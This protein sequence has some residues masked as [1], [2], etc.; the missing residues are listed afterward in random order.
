MSKHNWDKAFESVIVH[1][2][3]YVDHPSDPGGATNL[4][5]T[6]GTLSGWLGRKA[7]KAEVRALTK[8][9]VKPIYKKNYW[10]VVRGDD[11]P[12]GV[13]YAMFDFGVNS[14]PKR[15]VEFLQRIVGVTVDGRMGPQ[16]LAAVNKQ[17]ARVV[18]TKLCDSRLAWLKGLSTWATFGRG[19]E[20]RV[21]EV[22]IDGLSMALT[23][24][25]QD[26]QPTVPTNVAAA[27]FFALVAAIVYGV[28]KSIGVF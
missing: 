23:P 17:D 15:A 16:T 7:T 28:L 8:A 11:L 1:E 18:V 13:D 21:N 26:V 5:I 9:T 24:E 14:G 3:G 12:S 22:K 19:W 20:R 2:G 10:D 4:G 25:E 6:I 27:A